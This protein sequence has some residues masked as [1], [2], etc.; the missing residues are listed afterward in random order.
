[1]LGCAVGRAGKLEMGFSGRLEGEG[2]GGV[3]IGRYMGGGTGW[4]GMR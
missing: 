4:G 2:E 3:W 1:M